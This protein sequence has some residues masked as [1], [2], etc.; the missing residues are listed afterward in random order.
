MAVHIVLLAAAALFV[1]IS[2]I[3]NASF[4]SSWGRTPFEMGLLVGLSVAADAV[5]AV[6]PVV[7]VRNLVLRAWTH[8]AMAGVM[9]AGVIVLSLV[10]GLGFTALTRGQAYQSRN[11]AA[12]QLMTVETDLKDIEQQ[13]NRT[14]ESR[15]LAVIGGDLTR[16]AQHRLWTVSKSCT[17]PA[18]PLARQ[19]CATVD[20]LRA[21]HT[22]AV[23]HAR[24][25]VERATLRATYDTLAT[26]G[27][28]RDADPQSRL[29]AD[30]LGVP[31]TMPR[32]AVTT[33]L[34]LLLELGS[35]VLILLAVGPPQRPEAI[36]PPIVTAVVPMSVDRAH[37]QNKRSA[38]TMRDSRGLS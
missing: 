31:V 23:T 25:R 33:A 20:T 18:G 28:G 13:I 19:H 3:M 29:I 7:L 27:A 24:L 5:K 36:P 37:W 9:L 38:N 10:S 32:L 21:E 34:A 35:I 11:H 30:L 17:E 4:L 6:L 15:P 2:A 22:V 8:T 16:L 14:S 1:G 12:A 26:Q